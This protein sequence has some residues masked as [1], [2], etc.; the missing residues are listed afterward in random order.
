MDVHFF[1]LF[2][3]SFFSSLAFRTLQSGVL[4]PAKSSYDFFNNDVCN[5]VSE[6][7]TAFQCGE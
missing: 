7:G 1:F 6:T 3:F 5:S 4:Q 2:F